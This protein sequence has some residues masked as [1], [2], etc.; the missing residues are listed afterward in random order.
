MVYI[1]FFLT[2][3]LGCFLILRVPFV[4]NSG[5]SSRT[6]LVLFVL[7]IIAGL[8][9]GYISSAFGKTGDNW[10]VNAWSVMELELLKSNPTQFFKELIVSNYNG[11]GYD[12]LFGSQQSYW[13]DL[14]VNILGK[15]LA[16]FNFISNGNY[17]IN[18]IFYNFLCFL[19]HIALYRVFINIYP[20][21]KIA[22]LAGV[23][24]LPAFM[25]TASTIGK[26]SLTFVMVAFCCFCIY[27]FTM[28]GFTLKRFL[29]L[30][31]FFA[32]L[33]LLRNYAAFLFIPPA[34][35][36]YASIRFKLN[37]YK[38]FGT[39]L[40]LLTALLLIVPAII[41]SINP[42]STIYHKQQ[43]F[44]ALGI[45][46]SQI[47]AV[48]IEPTSISL[49]KNL[50]QAMI[51]GYLRPLLFEANQFFPKLLALEICIYMLIAIIAFF[52]II[53]NKKYIKPHSFI[54]FC[55]MFTALVFILNGYI[56]PNTNALVRYRSI[57]L[58]LIII[59]LLCNLPINIKIK[60]M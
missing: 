3:L 32:G 4:K 9:A 26:D 27:F 37:A 36:F 17:Y 14:D 40:L 5:L 41:P 57:F 30:F 22:I 56:V 58:P 11:E 1:I 48:P 55:I 47:D 54:L 42:A 46:N 50:P 38:V 59:P 52:F 23:F 44:L 21:K 51:N 25:Y 28:A 29:W 6:I 31:V 49:I 13:N 35:A 19:G 15:T 8:F 24:L 18:S 39:M 43:D 34:L 20:Q 53:R 2:F 16:P 33:F 45:A 60:N 10:L 12:N 7:K